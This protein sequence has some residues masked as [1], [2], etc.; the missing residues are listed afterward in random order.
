MEKITL[1]IDPEINNLKN[2]LRALSA[3]ILVLENELSEI[4]KTIHSFDVKQ[5]EILGDIILQIL[6]LRKKIATKK[7]KENPQDK[8]AQNKYQE[9]ETDEKEYKGLY[10][11]AKTN[12]INQLTPDE[13]QELKSLF[14][15]ISKLTHPDLVDKKFEKQAAEL[16]DKAKKAK[17]SNDL[18]TLKEILDYLVNG[19]PFSLKQETIT[20]NEALKKEVDHL[21]TV[22]LQLKQKLNE[23]VNSDTYKTIISIPNWGTYFTQTKEKLQ[24]E[25]DNLKSLDNEP[26]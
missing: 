14:R 10:E 6:D 13:E 22:I 4:D 5:I 9:T 19:T 17:D 12:P 18:K 26:V 24:Q 20:E 1:Y 21:R 16:F 2:E 8:E 11:D 15:K 25:L 23:T 7:V 3:E